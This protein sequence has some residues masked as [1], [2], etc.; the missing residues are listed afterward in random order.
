MAQKFVQDYFFTVNHLWLYACHVDGFRYD[1]VPNYWDGPPGL[2]YSN[3]VFATSKEV[4]DRGPVVV[5]SDS[6][7]TASS[8]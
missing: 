6:S 3:L 8:T 5:G 4:R 2:G 1:C 7:T